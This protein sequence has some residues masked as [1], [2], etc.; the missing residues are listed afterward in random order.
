MPPL[1]KLSGFEVSF[2]SLDF[3]N[4]ALHL[5]MPTI[6]VPYGLLK[7]LSSINAQ[8]ILKWLVIKYVMNLCVKQLL[9][10][11]FLQDFRLQIYLPKDFLGHGTNS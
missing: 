4:L 7:I 6:P 9:F 5:F 8:N 2:L 3:Y 1:L 10:L 11:M